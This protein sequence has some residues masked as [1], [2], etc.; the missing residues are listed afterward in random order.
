[1]TDIIQKLMDGPDDDVVVPFSLENVDVRGRVV[2]LGPAITGILGRHDYPD[3]VARVLGE[4]VALTALLGTSLKFDGRFI[5]Q[6]RTDGPIDLLV[7]DFSSPGNLRGY[8]HFDAELVAKIIAEGSDT[9]MLGKGNL[10]MTVDQGPDMENY[11][12]V[13]PLERGTL[14]DAALE[15]FTRSEQIPTKIHLGAGEIIS[16]MDGKAGSSSWRAGGILIQHLPPSGPVDME[17]HDDEGWDHA[18]A[19]FQT[20][21]YDE[22]L[23][24][25]LT[26]ENLLFRLYHDDGVRVMP[27]TPVEEV[28]RCSEDRVRTTLS[29]F[30]AE[31]LVD[32]VDDGAIRV[33]CEFC[34]RV[35]EFTPEDFAT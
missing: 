35:Y 27:S 30:G 10:A 2:R 24:P 32:M 12:G 20:V 23:D 17:A 26:P 14:V 22:I 29:Q 21:E 25:E 3:P 1:M 31:E 16:A 11:Q 34:N 28:C 15:Y 18:T 6:A 8:A 13:V 19:L 33:T 4:A 9:P 7:A 5:V